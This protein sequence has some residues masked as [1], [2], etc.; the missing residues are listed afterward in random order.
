MFGI[1]D[2]FL[3]GVI[4]GGLKLLG[5]QSANQANQQMYEIDARSGTRF[6]EFIEAHWGVSN[7]DSVS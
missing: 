1:D 4:G 5:Q 3:G 2:A 6:P 7:P